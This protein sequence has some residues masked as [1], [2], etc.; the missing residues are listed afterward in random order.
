MDQTTSTAPIS[1]KKSAPLFPFFSHYMEIS[2][3]DCFH[4]TIWPIPF[5]ENIC[6]TF[7]IFFSLHENYKSWLFSS[8]SLTSSISRKK[9]APLFPFISHYMEFSNLDC[10]HP[11]IWP[12]PFHEKICPTFPIFF[13][14][15]G[16]FQSWL[17]PPYYLTS[18][19]SRKNLPHFSHFFLITWKFQILTVSILIF[20]LFDFTKKSAPLFPF[21]F[22]YMTLK[23]NWLFLTLIAKKKFKFDSARAALQIGEFFYYMEKIHSWLIW[24]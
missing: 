21:F 19:L 16:I 20:G 1:W 7:P 6:P 14:L 23:Q 15:H 13:S 12:L 3:L 10:F 2:N 22:D 4:P 24:A 11:T 18:S 17:F 8:Y 9:S 5:H